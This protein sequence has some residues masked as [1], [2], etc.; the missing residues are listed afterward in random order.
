MQTLAHYMAE[1]YFNC[2]KHHR[3]C[4][5]T[6]KTKATVCKSRRDCQINFDI[7]D[8]IEC[9][10]ESVIRIRIPT[11]GFCTMHHTPYLP[12]L[13]LVFVVFDF[14]H[15]FNWHRGDNYHRV[16]ANEAALENMGE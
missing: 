4:A 7:Q 2:R 10:T 3:S 15:I 5:K 14:I 8:Y 1:W 12:Y 13:V 9:I 6:N 16:Y 11:I